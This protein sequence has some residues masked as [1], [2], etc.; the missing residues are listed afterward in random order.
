MLM[1]IV[2]NSLIS[3]FKRRIHDGGFFTDAF[4]ASIIVWLVVGIVRF[5][6]LVL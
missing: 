5:M 3:S 6:M 2:M 4:I 1:E